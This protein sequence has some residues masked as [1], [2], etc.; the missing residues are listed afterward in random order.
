MQ[1]PE[2]DNGNCCDDDSH[3]EM[4]LHRHG[5]VVEAENPRADR[6]PRADSEVDPFLLFEEHRN[7]DRLEE[8]GNRKNS[9][10]AD[11]GTES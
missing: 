7:R 3:H 9:D 1:S 10:D 4:N 6:Q 2:F 5:I 8:V 11:G